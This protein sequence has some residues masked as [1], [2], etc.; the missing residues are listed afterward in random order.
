MTPRTVLTKRCQNPEHRDITIYQIV[1]DVYVT[2]TTQV[3]I[4]WLPG[5]NRGNSPDI[6][7]SEELF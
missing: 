1:L 3:C 5:L 4:R 2:A 6:M 7:I